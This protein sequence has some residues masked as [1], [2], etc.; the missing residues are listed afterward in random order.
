MKRFLRILTIL[1]IVLPMFMSCKAISGFFSKGEVV[2]R[3]GNAKLMMSD[4]ENVVPDGLSEEDSI[5]LAQ[6]YINSWA[7]DRLLLNMAE[8]QLSESERDVSKELDLYRTSLLKYKYE[9]LYVNQRLDTAVSETVIEEYYAAHQ[10]KFKLQRPLLKARFIS[11]DPDSPVLPE[12]K[13]K[14]SSDDGADILEADSLAFVSAFKS[15]MWNGNWIDA[16]TLTR[17]FES[18]YSSMASSLKVGWIERRDSVTLKLAYV[19][20]YIPAG[21]IS[22]L[23]YCRQDIVDM[24]ISTRKQQMITT[25]EQDL[26]QTSLENGKFEILK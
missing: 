18:D 5:R 14:M 1:G 15:T 8:K 26:L 10:E 12:L 22:P 20:D 2:A 7:L 17:E 9:Q 21:R 11:I 3:V 16:V 25:L 13:Q 4:L 23:E 19:S 6:Q 24:I